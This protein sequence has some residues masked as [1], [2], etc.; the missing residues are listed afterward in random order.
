MNEYRI[1]YK[2]RELEQG[3][4]KSE[5][6]SNYAFIKADSQ[7][8][9]FKELFSQWDTAQTEMTVVNITKTGAQ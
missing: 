7:K 3:F 1:D 6:K 4:V 2:W 5:Y 8:E 9:A